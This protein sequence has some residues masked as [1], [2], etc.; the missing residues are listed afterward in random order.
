PFFI[1]SLTRPVKEFFF[2]FPGIPTA[3]GPT[4]D[5]A[6]EEGKSRD[7][8]GLLPFLYGKSVSKVLKR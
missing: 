6:R 3:P 5:P 4:E 1:R 2:A 8:A 7:T